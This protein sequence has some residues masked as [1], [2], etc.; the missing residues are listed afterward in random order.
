MR[1]LR[2]LSRKNELEPLSIRVYRIF[3]L[4]L[5][6]VFIRLGISP[7]FVTLLSIASAVIGAVLIIQGTYRFLVCGAL[8]LVFSYLLDRCDGEL[9]RYT[10]KLTHYGGYLEVLNSNVLYS[11]VFVGLAV[12]TYRLLGDVNMLWFGISA[13]LFKFMFRFND[14][15]KSRV[16]NSLARKP[17]YTPL[18]FD[19]TSP[20]YKR[21]LWEVYM[22]LFCGGGMVLLVLIFAVINKP[23]ILLMFYGVT[24]PL[25]F[26]LQSYLHWVDLR[27]N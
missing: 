4:Y 15:I 17:R 23:N 18:G 2:E 14:N 13:L 22:F 24:M 27:E 25:L 12:G 5:T 20:I 19:E 10:G 16:M 3:S 8:A 9:A 1:K 11:S 7:N 21:I 6:A 26:L